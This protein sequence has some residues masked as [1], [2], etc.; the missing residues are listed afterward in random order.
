MFSQFIWS[1][2]DQVV[3]KILKVRSYFLYIIFGLGSNWSGTMLADSFILV[4]WN[5]ISHANCADS[6]EAEVWLLF[7]LL[8]SILLNRYKEA[9]N[10]PANN[11]RLGAL[12][13]SI[14]CS[15]FCSIIWDL[16]SGLQLAW[17]WVSKVVVIFG[18]NHGNPIPSW[19]ET[20]VFLVVGQPYKPKKFKMAP[21]KS[22]RYC[23]LCYRTCLH[24]CWT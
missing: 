9:R 18:W 23:F 13:L 2:F 24:F 11:Y 5:L 20:Q 19:F 6:S 12:Y 15:A 17:K 3:W 8:L 16:L 14:S 4:L 1:V 10:N 7:F 22:Y 21:G